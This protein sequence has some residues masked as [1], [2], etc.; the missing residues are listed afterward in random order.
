[1]QLSD[2]AEAFA[3]S[4]ST[5]KRACPA[6]FGA[7]LADRRARRAAARIIAGATVSDAAAAVGVS[8]DHLTKLFVKKYGVRPGELRRALQGASKVRA[9]RA[10]ELPAPGS[11]WYYEQ[12]WQWKAIE[13]RFKRLRADVVPGTDL[14]RW[15]T[16][17]ARQVARPDYRSR[18]RV[19]RDRRYDQWNR[20]STGRHRRRFAITPRRSLRVR[21]R[22]R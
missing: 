1:M 9:W 4:P 7:L 5:I 17:A 14:E 13:R 19:S 15:L 22:A 12:R 8:S 10:R 21:G 16:D 11:P 6:G 2:L 18:P 20:Y 3:C